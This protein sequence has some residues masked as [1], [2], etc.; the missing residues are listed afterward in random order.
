MLR[1]WFRLSAGLGVLAGVLAAVAGACC[2]ITGVSPLG[3]ALAGCLPAGLCLPLLAVASALQVE[4]RPALAGRVRAP[5]PYAVLLL[6]ALAAQTGAA[7]AGH[8]LP[9][10]EQIELWSG[11]WGWAAQPVV[12]AAG[13][14]AP[15][16]P[17]SLVALAVLTAGAVVGAHRSA[18][19]A[20]R[21]SCGPARRR[22]PR[23]PR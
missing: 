13:G 15:G 23:C 11:P 8:R 10:L 14:S 4:S 2:C 5:T 20:P 7:W 19:S 1:P 9:V 22:P 6:V 18:A 16:W 12:A 17:A 3:G 21:H